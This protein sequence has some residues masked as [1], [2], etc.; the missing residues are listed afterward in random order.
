MK[1]IFCGGGTA[2]HLYPGIAVAQKLIKQCNEVMF[3]GVKGKLEETIVPKNGFEIKF[4]SSAGI[5]RK[6]TAKILA[7]VW[8][9][10]K[11]FFQALR[12]IN[13]YKPKLIFAT[14]G[15][16]CVPVCLAAYFSG[17]PVVIHEQNAYPGIANRL[18]SLFAKITAL[19]YD[20]SRVYFKRKCTCVLTGN[21]VREE[22][23]SLA[24]EN[25][26]IRN[27]KKTLLVMGGSQGAD[28]INNVL[29]NGI[30]N[31]SDIYGIHI[32]LST[33][34]NNYASVNEKAISIMDNLS[35]KGLVEVVPFIEDM[36]T[37]LKNADLIVSRA[38]ATTIAEIKCAGKPVILIPYPY[39]TG[40]H[41]TFN[42]KSAVTQ[43]FAYMISNA[44]IDDKLVPVIR[45]LLSD[46]DLLVRMG[47]RALESNS[48][49]ASEVLSELIT[50]CANQYN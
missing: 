16:V 34:R 41:Q 39:A 25:Q 22:I 18:V 49:N 15:F 12:I 37:A 36:R 43:G 26:E 2:G 46:E 29:I 30:E 47:K 4:I 19:T 9:N 33:G 35:K 3:I 7:Q 14:G 50:K 38:G 8:E 44:D 27:G 24:L 5:S 23:E 31:L 17:V 13:E 28:K 48:N 11:G 42:A 45:E 1:Y 32:I 6:F 20:E 40:D 21:P 10:V